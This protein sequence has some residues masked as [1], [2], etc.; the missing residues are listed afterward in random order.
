MEQAR[1]LLQNNFN[2][3]YLDSRVLKEL[4]TNEKYLELVAAAQITGKPFMGIAARGA[5]TGLGLCYSILAAVAK[6]HLDQKWDAVTPLNREEKVLLEKAAGITEKTILKKNGLELI[7]DDEW[8]NLRRIFRKLLQDKTVVVQ[9]SG[10]VGGSTID[11][12]KYYGINVIAIA[13]KDGAIIGDHLVID[14]LLNAAKSEGTIIGVTTNV[15]KTI[16]GAAEGTAVL[17]L[18]CDILIPAALE[19]TITIANAGRIKTMLMV[20]GSNGPSTSKAENILYRNG[21]T[22]IYDFLANGGGVTVSYF[23]WLRNLADRFKFEAEHI[24]KRPFDIN[25]MDPYVMPEFNRRI[26]DILL[27]EESVETTRGWNL[28]LRDIIF[29]A[30]N[31]DYEAAKSEGVSMKTMGFVNTILRVLT[32]EMLKMTPADRKK[33]FE[34]LPD[35]AKERLYGCLSHPEAAL[36]APDIR[37]IVID[38]Y[39][40][41][42]EDALAF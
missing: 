22:V 23:E 39:G 20:C 6:L 30:V 29:A 19:N 26:K 40:R 15:S 21:V 7:A 4:T 8:E 28:V 37:N 5:A 10:K 38:L 41:P 3:N 14:E 9:G 16:H 12:L 27:K 33:H 11:E 25:V 31:E 42:P 35:A 34:A 36:H 18:P 32:A 13:D 1:N 2:I 24:E 17:E